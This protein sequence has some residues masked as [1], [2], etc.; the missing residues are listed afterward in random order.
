MLNNI[1]FLDEED[2]VDARPP[3]EAYSNFMS[4]L[5]DEIGPKVLLVAYNG[6]RFDYKHMERLLPQFGQ[7]NFKDTIIGIADP[8]TFVR[9]GFKG[10]YKKT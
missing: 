4:W 7:E 2:P 10:E 6:W 9:Q 5:R 8:L 3:L 1:F